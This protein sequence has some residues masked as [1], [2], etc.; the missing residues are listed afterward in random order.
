MKDRVFFSRRAA[1]I[2]TGLMA[3]LAV[4]LILALAACGGSDADAE[5]GDPG[6]VFGDPDV[7]IDLTAEVVDWEVYPGETVE[8]WVYNGSY[9]GPEFRVT[10]GEKVRVNITN[11][12]PEATT[13]HWH[14]LDVPNDQ[15]GVPGITQPDI[16]PGESWTYEFVAERV[17]TSVYHTHSNTAAQLAK[18]LFGFFIVEPKADLGYDREY[19]L[20][21]H[22]IAGA[23][24]IN[25][26]SFPATLDDSFLK[27]KTGETILVRFANMGAQY[28]PFHLHGH[29]F[30]VTNIDGNS[31][32]DGWRQNT[33][34]IPPGQTV[35]VVIEGTNP[36]TW[37]FHCHIVPHVT[38]KGEYPGG[39]LTLLDYEDHTSYM[40]EQAAAAEEAE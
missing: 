23:Y 11:N 16:E 34:D 17:G 40:E 32:P 6:F 8:A 3:S 31:M 7:D 4:G 26:K 2:A 5:L 19:S 21:L 27:I 13:V 33:I 39:M 9:P 15:D 35:D 30:L 14:G 24:T 25:G 12:L 10:E 36:G 20:A 37:T 29:Q 38:N 28:H 18:G 1:V 22:E